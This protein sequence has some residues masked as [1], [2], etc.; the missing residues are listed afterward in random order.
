MY[1][2]IRP[3][4]LGHSFADDDEGKALKTAKVREMRETFLAESLPM[5]MGHYVR[6]LEGSGGAYFCGAELTIA[7][8]MVL[9]QL[10]YF[11]KG[12]ADFV[13]AECLDPYPVVTAWITRMYEIP[14]IKAWYKLEAWCDLRAAIQ[15]SGPA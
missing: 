12:V 4:S 14:E 1:M 10:R 13:P 2:G 7:D 5:L 15:P 9:A 11:Q 6:I 8:L 3:S